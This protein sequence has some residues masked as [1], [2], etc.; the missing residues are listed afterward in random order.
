VCVSSPAGGV[1][2]QTASG[3]HSALLQSC[4][5]PDW[6]SSTDAPGPRQA[7]RRRTPTSSFCA[8]GGFLTGPCT[9]AVLGQKGRV[10]GG[11]SK[12]WIEVAVMMIMMSGAKATPL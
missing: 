6:W 10:C 2:G 3:I 7:G 8:C 12:G 5:V 4:I 11:R 9:L 1:E